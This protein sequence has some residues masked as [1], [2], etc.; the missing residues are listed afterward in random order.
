MTVRFGYK[1]CVKPQEVTKE[2]R[3]PYPTIAE[4]S[5]GASPTREA[6]APAVII[7]AIPASK[8]ET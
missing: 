3:I 8:I 4:E 2:I 5:L 1:K 6:I 7:G